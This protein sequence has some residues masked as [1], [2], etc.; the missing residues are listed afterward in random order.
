M[1]RTCVHIEQMLQSILSLT[2]NILAWVQK[3]Q[4]LLKQLRKEK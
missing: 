2:D 3:Y 4:D 1:F